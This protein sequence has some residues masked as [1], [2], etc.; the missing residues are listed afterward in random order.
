MNGM[1][2]WHTTMLSDKT[3][4]TGCGCSL[5][6]WWLPNGTFSNEHG[7]ASPRFLFFNWI[8]FCAVLTVSLFSEATRY[9]VSCLW[10]SA[11]TAMSFWVSHL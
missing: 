3:T 4:S 6:R 10:L 7:N 9:Y 2:R 8:V 11:I 1:L 5:P